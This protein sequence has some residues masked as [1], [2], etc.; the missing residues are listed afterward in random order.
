M[1]ARSKA[2]QRLFG[3]ALAV[4][5]G[6][7]KKSEAS[8]E[9]LKIANSKMTDQQIHDF[10]A[11]KKLRNHY[12]RGSKAAKERRRREKESKSLKEYLYDAEVNR[13]LEELGIDINDFIEENDIFEDEKE[14][15]A[16][17]VKKAEKEEKN[18]N[19]RIS[20]KKELS[21]YNTRYA[22]GQEQTLAEEP[23]DK[24]VFIIVKPGF[25]LL[26]QQIIKEFEN[27]GFKLYQT[28]V[29][30]LTLKEAKQLYAVHKEEEWYDALCKYM[31]SDKTLGVTFNYTGKWE[32]A[33]KKTDE[34]KDMFR[35]KYSES[36]MRNVIHSSDSKENMEKESS[37]YF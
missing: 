9:V 28:C 36:D 10:A 25:F 24:K 11:T 20:K 29:K 34:L 26:A 27:Q 18:T 7:M 2:Q 31:S 12:V 19:R 35:K 30:K 21:S 37:I 32:K 13:V 22:N 16:K 3:M 15:A 4:R 17:N 5:R 23:I 1:P 6:D 33:L 8:P 14:D